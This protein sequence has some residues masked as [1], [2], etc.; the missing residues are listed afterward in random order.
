MLPMMAKLPERIQNV[1]RS[2]VQEIKGL[3]QKLSKQ[4]EANQ[5]SG[6]YSRY[7]LIFLPILLNDVVAQKKL[8]YATRPEI[9]ISYENESSD[10]GLFVRA[11]PLELKSIVSN[12]INNAIEAYGSCGGKVSIKSRAE[13]SLCK[14][15]V[16]D[17]GV[18]I[19]KDF[20]NQL[21]TKKI[22]FKADSAR[23]LG[24]MHAFKVI[25]AASGKIEIHSE[26]G[27]GTEIKVILPHGTSD[28]GNE[29]SRHPSVDPPGDCA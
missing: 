18:G 10:Q 8:E 1:L 7:D 11:D 28:S 5:G 17:R 20:I 24:L 26:L 16:T 4:A 21:G 12:L 29:I 27:L 22:T 14:I 19:P 9:E 3:S 25:E 13:G 2:S 15:T 23:G 6:V